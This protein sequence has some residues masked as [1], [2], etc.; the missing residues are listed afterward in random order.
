MVSSRAPS[1][2]GGKRVWATYTPGSTTGSGSWS[3]LVYSLPDPVC[4]ASF[5]RYSS[6]LDGAP[7]N[8]LLFANPASSS[9][10]HRMTVRM[11]EDEG[12]TWTVSR[13]VDD[14]PAAYSDMAVLPDGTV[15]LLYETGGADAYE[16]LTLVRF[17]LDWL[18]QADLDSDGDGMSDYYEGINGLN[19]GADDAGMDLDS[20]GA[21]NLVESK[22]GTMAN[23]V[24]SVF[25]IESFS[26]H[27]DG[28]SLGWA[29]VPG[30]GYAIE[31]APDL[32]GQ[33]SLEPDAGD[34]Y[35]P[36]GLRS[37]LLPRPVAPQRFFRVVV[38][39][40]R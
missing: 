8:R 32:S 36:G 30:I 15:G 1:G 18:T 5:L 21:S 14:R 37:F 17:D 24:A 27:S 7:R 38:R 13:Q 19:A 12:Q 3:P 9:S 26:S 28:L 20:D 4:Q 22:A 6:T 40:S 16:T 25:R 34:L 11:S 31:G 39:A 2:G 33:W 10:R 29:S 23:D 35:A